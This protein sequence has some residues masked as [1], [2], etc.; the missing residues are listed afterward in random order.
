MVRLYGRAEPAACSRAMPAAAA[1]V[2]PDGDVLHHRPGEA[3]PEQAPLAA[4]ALAQAAVHPDVQ[5]CARRHRI[6]PH[7]AQPRRRAGRADRNLSLILSA[8]IGVEFERAAALSRHPR[9]SGNPETA[10]TQRLPWTPAFA[11]V[12]INLAKRAKL[13]VGAVDAVQRSG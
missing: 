4:A 7:P 1:A 2:Q 11:R 9:E 10:I 6:F 13:L 3:R 8:L 12:T 5:Q